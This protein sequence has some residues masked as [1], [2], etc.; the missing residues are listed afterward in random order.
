MR[1][2]LLLL[3]IVSAFGKCF[4]ESWDSVYAA[5]LNG[6]SAYQEAKLNLK[7]AEVNYNK[8]NKHY[9][10][11]ISVSTANSSNS[12]DSG[13]TWDGDSGW[14]GALVP[15]LTFEN[16]LA[17]ADISLKAPVALSGTGEPYFQNPGISVS[18]SL[19]PE[20]A[21][22]T[23]EAEAGLMSAGAALQSIQGDV[24][25]SLVSDILRAV[26]YRKLL[27]TSRKNL[28]VL[29]AVRT[30]TVDSKKI[31][32]IEKSVLSAQKAILEAT[33]N[34]ADIRDDVKNNA[35]SLYADMVSRQDGWL[36]SI[37][38][39]QPAGSKSIRSIELQLAAAEK[40]QSFSALPYLPNPT[41]SASAYYDTEKKSVGWG[42]SFK[43]AYTALDQGQNSLNVLKR[44]E[45][46][47]IY[48]VKLEDAQKELSD[49]I[50]KINEELRALDLDRKIKDIELSDARDET[51]RKTTLYGAGFVSKEEYT[52][53]QVDLESLELEAEKIGFD[54]LL[55]KLMLARYYEE[56]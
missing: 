30:A 45:Y 38:G 44:E 43:L 21:A 49:S 13:I 56:V 33:N 32:A 15:A 22:N 1:R 50:R 31:H 53:A 8:Y 26:H 48:K 35:E 54:I 19:F 16:V 2:Y 7:S 12:S 36:A 23:L 4:A 14:S 3:I 10:P 37:K 20:T 29:Q 41:I 28:E 42:L 52:A 5:H 34:L 55:K 24:R 18:R 46:P 9:I 40:R 51:A 47:K 11:G 17:G 25:I 6:S 27:E 39:D